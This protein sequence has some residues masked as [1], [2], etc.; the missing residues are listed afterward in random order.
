MLGTPDGNCAQSMAE[1]PGLMESEESQ[2]MAPSN[3]KLRLVR[4]LLSVALWVKH[5]NL[6]Q[7]SQQHA[8]WDLRSS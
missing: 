4:T 1:S 5:P 8:Y 7:V 6:W 2:L 3:K